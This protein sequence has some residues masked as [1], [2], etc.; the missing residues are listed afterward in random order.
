MLVG[1]AMDTLERSQ[2]PA[3]ALPPGS[4]AALALPGLGGGGQS[5]D[6]LEADTRL[7][8]SHVEALLASLQ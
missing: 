7:V 4:I 3:A 2:N 1:R 6:S 5:A 8:A